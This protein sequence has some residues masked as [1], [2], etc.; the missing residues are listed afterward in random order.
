MYKL[1]YKN[2][3]SSPGLVAVD[4]VVVVSAIVSA[5]LVVVGARLTKHARKAG[6]L[7]NV[8]ISCINQ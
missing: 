2:V 6:Y 5:V 1:E 8:H 7:R 4:P 3:T